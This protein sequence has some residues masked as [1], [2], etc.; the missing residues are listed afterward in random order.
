MS[1]ALPE[2]FVETM[3]QALGEEADSLFAAL[4]TEPV[5]SI[6]LNPYKPAE[7]FDGEAIGWSPN[8]RYL[9]SR[10][11]FTLDAPMHGGAY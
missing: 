6:R 9:A 4:D 1:I 2:K 11:Q 5:V 7:L 8:G 3:R 10:P